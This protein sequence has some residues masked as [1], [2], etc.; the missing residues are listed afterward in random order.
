MIF[1]SW[2]CWHRSQ[3][4]AS[5]DTVSERTVYVFSAIFTLASF[6]FFAFT[7]LPIAY[8]PDITFPRPAEFVPAF[9][10]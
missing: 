2:F 8:F 1:L 4:D 3:R 6:L 10:S 9:F 7:P 5:E